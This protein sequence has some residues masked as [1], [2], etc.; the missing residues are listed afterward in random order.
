MT[1]RHWYAANKW[2]NRVIG[3]LT[4]EERDTL[5]AEGGNVWSPIKA[6]SSLV[7][8][9]RNRWEKIGGGAIACHL[10]EVL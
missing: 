1:K 7:K 6:D 4:R 5:V 9:C 8:A 10:K 3:F 2:R